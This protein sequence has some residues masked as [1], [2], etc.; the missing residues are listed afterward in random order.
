MKNILKTTPIQ[1][2]LIF[3]YANYNLTEQ[4]FICI[5]KMLTIDPLFIDLITFL[6]VSHNS[7][8]LISSLVNKKVIKLVDVD[9]KMMINL[10]GLYDIISGERTEY[11]QVGLSNDQIDKL[12]HIFNK[13]MNP[14]EVLKINSWMAAG[15]DFSKIEESIYIALAKGITNLNY[16]E[17]IIVNANSTTEEVVQ[18][19]RPVKRNWTY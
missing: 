1:N 14:N 10:N 5:C 8:P 7:K 19:E 12:N 6:R 9:G 13:K 11:E 18:K 2:E 3:N 15:A 4:E 16:I 17:K